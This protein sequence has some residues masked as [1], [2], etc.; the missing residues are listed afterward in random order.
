MGWVF[1]SFV[2]KTKETNRRKIPGKHMLQ[3]ALGFLN[4]LRIRAALG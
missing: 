3:P 2:L 1:V 4:V